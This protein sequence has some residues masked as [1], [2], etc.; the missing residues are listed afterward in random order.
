M[1]LVGFGAALIAAFTNNLGFLYRH[2]GAT[3]APDVSMKTPWASVKGL[4]R[5]KWWTIGYIVAFVAWGFHVA[6]L[7]LAP[8]SLVQAVLAGGFVFLAILADRFFGFTLRKRE[9]FGIALVAL[10]LL[11]LSLTGAAAREGSGSDY[12]I[13]AM[14]VFEGGLIIFGAFCLLSH[15]IGDGKGKTTAMLLATAAGLMFS[16][17][18][19]GI[20]GIAGSVQLGT[21]PFL[22]VAFEDPLA[23][24]APLGLVIVLAAI[25]AF[26][27]S[28]R[29]L[30]LGDAV[31]V[32]AVTGIA[33]NATAIVGGVIVFGDPVGDSALEI[34]ARA[35]AFALIVAAAAIIP[36]PMRAANSQA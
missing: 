27:A 10:G 12:R 7:A 2:R 16:V 23:L 24:I 5:Q 21:G 4:F 11:V 20:K 9:W 29:S 14:V 34:T 1:V 32:I 18:H 25:I 35:L 30:Q 33:G 22:E 3:S 28:A 36:G 15:R 17:T 31:A 19:I 26:Y 13:L 8:L 6:A